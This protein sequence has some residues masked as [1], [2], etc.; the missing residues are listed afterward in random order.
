ML[1][2][3]QLQFL[4]R[5][6]NVCNPSKS[7]FSTGVCG[8]QLEVESSECSVKMWPAVSSSTPGGE[9]EKESE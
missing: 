5:S 7:P 9:Q 6:I 4:Q 8:L 2:R 1:K 3:S